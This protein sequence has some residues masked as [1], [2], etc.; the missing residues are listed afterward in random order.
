MLSTDFSRLET[1]L[2]NVNRTLGDVIN[3]LLGEHFSS[4]ILNYNIFYWQATFIWSTSVYIRGVVIYI[5][6]WYI[7]I[8]CWYIYKTKSSQ[9]T[10]TAEIN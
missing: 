4:Q 8:K 7:Y 5:K 10:Y 9:L 3:V 2:G 1:Q 6:R